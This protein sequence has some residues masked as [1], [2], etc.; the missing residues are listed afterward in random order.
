MVG[1]RTPLGRHFG[2]RNSFS[3]VLSVL[4]SLFLFR[5]S[6]LASIVI[7]CFSSM[8]ASR[9]LQVVNR[10]SPCKSSVGMGCKAPHLR[11]ISSPDFPD[12]CC[13][14]IAFNNLGRPVITWAP[15]LGSYCY[16]L[17]NLTMLYPP[18]FLCICMY[19]PSR[20]ACVMVSPFPFCCCG[21]VIPLS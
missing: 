6:A 14:G 7:V 20:W 15:V 11:S 4:L 18:D 10:L 8:S 21:G 3:G 19:G 2:S 17:G 13:K 9:R 1:P 12:G 16:Y 5:P